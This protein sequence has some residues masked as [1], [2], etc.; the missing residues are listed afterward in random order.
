[1]SPQP[2]P[3]ASIAT[4]RPRRLPPRLPARWAPWLAGAKPC[5]A[6]LLQDGLLWD[7]GSAR[8][9]F[10]PLHQY[11][12]FAAWCA[13]Y[14]G[15]VCDLWLSGA[16]VHELVCDPALPLAGDAALVAHARAVFAHYHGA[17][18]F[19]WHLAPWSA[20]GQQGVS[21]LHGV[22]LGQL[23]AV[24]RAHGV[25][26]RGLRPWWVRVLSLALQRVST[27]R[28]HPRVWLLVVEGRHVGALRLHRG[29]VTELQS[30]WLGQARPQPLAQL[31]N[32]LRSDPA[33]AAAS[34][35]SGPI[36]EPASATPVFAVGFGLDSG[37]VAG[38]EC[39]CDLAAAAPAANWL[40]TV[41]GPR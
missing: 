16:F 11:T 15:S 10:A 29:A 21:A 22:D 36:V 20:R 32:T 26:V 31:A 28:S 9:A 4:P 14:P 35:T 25:R 18:S 7:A 39:L 1:M 3:A 41:G 27:L 12:D 13:T 30:L 5:H 40:L 34:G 23:L 33:D 6:L 8:D 19:G 37:A 2:E 24:S 38:I 17:P